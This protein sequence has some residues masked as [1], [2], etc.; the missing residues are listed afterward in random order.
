MITMR[1]PNSTIVLSWDLT[2][3][4]EIVEAG[5]VP[6]LADLYLRMAM[7]ETMPYDGIGPGLDINGPLRLVLE[8]AQNNVDAGGTAVGIAATL[9]AFDPLADFDLERDGYRVI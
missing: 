8:W 5:P 7:L 6:A 9:E 4:W 2:R 3:G 1:L